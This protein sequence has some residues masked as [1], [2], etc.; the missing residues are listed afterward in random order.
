MKKS[1]PI[2]LLLTLFSFV[3]MAQLSWSKQDHNFGISQLNIPLAYEF[4]YIN[5]S[6]KTVNISFIKTSCA[7]LK[8][9]WDKAILAPGEVGNLTITYIPMKNGGYKENVEIFMDNNPYPQIITVT[10]VVGQESIATYHE[11]SLSGTQPIINNPK[12]DTYVGKTSTLTPPNIVEKPSAPNRTVK[13]SGNKPQPTAP[14]KKKTAPTKT[15]VPNITPPKKNNIP[16][17][18]KPK[19]TKKQNRTNT[20]PV[21]AK[22]TPNKPTPSKPTKTNT[23]PSVNVANSTGSNDLGT[24]IARNYLGGE[25]LNTAVNETYLSTREKAMIK[26]I[27][28]VRSNPQAYI[29][30]VETYVQYMKSDDGDWYKD[31]IITAKELIE[32]LKKTPK[33]SI[34][35]PSRD[36]Y[37]AAKMHGEE[38]KKVGSLEHQGQD[39]SWPWDRVTKYDKTMKDGNENIV[40]GMKDIRKSVLTLLIDSGIEGRGHRKTM[41]KKEWTHVSAYDVGKVGEMPNMW[42]QKFGQAKNGNSTSSPNIPE[43]PTE[44]DAITTYETD[45]K[46]KPGRMAVPNRSIQKPNNMENATVMPNSLPKPNHSA[47]PAKPNS[48]TISKET[49]ASTNNLASN[50]RPSKNCYTTNNAVY[51]RNNEKEMIAEIN[52]LRTQPQEYIEVIEAYIEFMDNEISKDKSARIFYN[53]ELKSANELIEL[54]ERL[55]P[56][57]ALKPNK[58][59]YKAAKIHGEYGQASGNLEKQGSDGSMP[60]NRIMKYATEMMDGDE[61][62]PYGSENVRYSIIKLLIDKDDAKKEQRKILLNPNWDYIAVFEVGKVG[63]M[64][65]WVQD[66]GQARPEYKPMYD[67]GEVETSTPA[68]MAFANTE[69]LTPT[70]IA[71]EV[72]P[73]ATIFDGNNSA[74]LSKKEQILLREINFIRSN[75]TQY[76]QIVE[77]YIY[78]LQADKTSFPDKAN[79]YKKRIEAATFIKEELAKAKPKPVLKANADLYKAA[80]QHGQD[81]KENSSFTHWGSDGSN[82]WQR[83]QQNAPN[84]KDGDQC[85][86]SNTDDIRESVISMLID[87]A[88][89]S[90]NRENVLLKAN[91]TH[92]AASAI[93]DIG[94]R[95]D[96]WVIT[97]GAF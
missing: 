85:L 46:P 5:Y 35:L 20:Q 39:G 6:A 22:P 25:E 11:P 16:A 64:H 29:K 77:T 2:I 37:T 94:K 88:I 23:K 79:Y 48:V 89:Y 81:C 86:V 59:I 60:H 53:K 71:L 3:S 51:L 13:P 62:L 10:G 17:P 4:Q 82:T 49:T 26:E 52:F 67:V 40:G 38:A 87:H 76:A 50:I 58:G 12:I 74:F 31:E 80:Y 28:L 8:P 32:E 41:L 91:W 75:P 93:G 92:F 47:A 42:L 33:L 55:P 90:R 36:I 65:Y 15:Q 78:K 68:V 24:D 56:L 45:S 30:V 21:P 7:C 9:K 73:S 44:Y 1:L 63:N 84:I 27:N 61:N 34:L 70:A 14:K 43:Q 54:L 96:C 18:A 69:T 72:Q 57:N 66:F 19:V 95:K 83:L 97:F